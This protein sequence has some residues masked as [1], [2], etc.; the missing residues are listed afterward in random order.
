M[1]TFLAATV[2]ET[3]SKK[4]RRYL[5]GRGSE[6]DTV[7]VVNSLKGGDDTTD[8]DAADGE[9][10]MAE[11]AEGLPNTETHQLVRA[12]PR[13]TTSRSSPPSTPSTR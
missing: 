5:S 1:T 8:V 7:Y 6:A 13:R 3:T 12:T 4:L 11:R 10:A 2:S 9:R